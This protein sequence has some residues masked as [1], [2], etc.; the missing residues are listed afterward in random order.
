MSFVFDGKNQISRL[1][2]LNM[3]QKHSWSMFRDPA[4]N[5]C[6]LA[7]GSVVASTSELS[8][9]QPRTPAQRQQPPQAPAGVDTAS[10]SELAWPSGCAG[11]SV[12]VATASSFATRLVPLIAQLP[13]SSFCYHFETIKRN[14][15]FQSS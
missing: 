3:T 1:F 2:H 14:P 15:Q 10:A 11:D 13:V 6:S 5:V 12:Y 4:M 9:G 8:L 7:Q